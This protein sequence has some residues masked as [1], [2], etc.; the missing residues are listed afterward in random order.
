MI[1]LFSVSASG[2]KNPFSPR[3][4]ASMA[5]KKAVL[6]K[7]C[8]LFLLRWRFSCCWFFFLLR[9]IEIADLS[10]QAGMAAAN[11]FDRGNNDVLLLLIAMDIAVIIAA[12]SGELQQQFAFIGDCGVA[13]LDAE[14]GAGVE[15][16]VSTS[17]H[18]LTTCS[19]IVVADAAAALPS[20]AAGFCG[21]SLAAIRCWGCGSAGEL[22]TGSVGVCGCTWGLES[23]FDGEGAAFAARL[24]ADG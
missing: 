5:L 11:A 13:V 22:F 24:P 17:S 8:R 20:F 15:I 9:G 6:L 10:A 18:W 16:A 12:V 21:A 1:V 19:A 23:V 3:W 2:G 14:K 7:L 4:S